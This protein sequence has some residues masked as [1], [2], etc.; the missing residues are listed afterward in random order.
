[1]VS[2]WIDVTLFCLEQNKM[3]ALKFAQTSA[4]ERE[5]AFKIKKQQNI[6]CKQGFSKD[7]HRD[8]ERWEFNNN[9]DEIG[10]D[11]KA[12]FIWICEDHHF[13]AKIHISQLNILVI[14]LFNG[15]KHERLRGGGH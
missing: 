10:R 1:M 14:S 12:T 8:F 6:V 15:K 4:K 9:F 13:L 5:K 2:R 7:F 3:T 11:T